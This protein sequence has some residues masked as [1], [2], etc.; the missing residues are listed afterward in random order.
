MS[1]RANRHFG[2]IGYLGQM[3]VEDMWGLGQMDIWGN[4]YFET[5]EHWSK[6]A[7]GEVGIGGKWALGVNGHQDK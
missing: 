3:G 2:V 4:R 6:G 1:T 5:D 7:L